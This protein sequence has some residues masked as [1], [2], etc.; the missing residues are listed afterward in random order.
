[1]REGVQQLLSGMTVDSGREE[2][3]TWT[4]QGGKKE[5]V[6]TASL[7]ERCVQLYLDALTMKCVPKNP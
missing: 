6:N 1:M 3:G 4:N 2:N 7:M 5:T